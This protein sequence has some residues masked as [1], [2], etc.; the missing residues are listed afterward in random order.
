MLDQ[1]KTDI[2]E[3]LEFGDCTSHPIHR[4]AHSENVLSMGTGATDNAC[5][6]CSPSSNTRCSHTS[7]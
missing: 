2:E 5:M 4:M 6:M 3:A 1:I 7:C